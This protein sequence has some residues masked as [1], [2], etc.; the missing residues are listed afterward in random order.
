M[1]PIMQHTTWHHQNSGLTSMSNLKPP[2]GSIT[3]QWSA[4]QADVN[5]SLPC[6]E[7]YMRKCGTL[8]KNEGL[9]M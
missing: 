2:N 9:L 3:C 5:V 1:A 7:G 6:L 4:S 8:G